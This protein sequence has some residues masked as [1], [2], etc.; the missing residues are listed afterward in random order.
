MLSWCFPWVS[1]LGFLGGSDNKESACKAGDLGLI[2]G[3]GRKPGEGNGYSSILG[4]R[5]PWTE[6][7]GRLQ[8]LGVTKSWTRL[9][10]F[11]FFLIFESHSILLISPREELA[12]SSGVPL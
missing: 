3:S 8:S 10:D 11:F 2:P 7:P 9:R 12:L 6:E 5:I 4:W 1:L